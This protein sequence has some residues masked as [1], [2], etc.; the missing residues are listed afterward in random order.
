MLNIVTL[1]LNFWAI[2]KFLK[3]KF[4]YQL[5]GVPCLLVENRLADTHASRKPILDNFGRTRGILTEH[6]VSQ[7]SV[8]QM[9]FDQMSFDQ[10][11][12]DQMSFDQM[13]VGQMSFDQM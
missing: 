2:D 6:W 3:G 1:F 12:F 7:L 4:R 8:S 11:S 13:S 9:S 5:W 10:M